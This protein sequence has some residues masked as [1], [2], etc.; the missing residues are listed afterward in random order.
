MNHL[1]LLS[2]SLDVLLFLSENFI[3]V[4]ESSEGEFSRLTGHG[5]KQCYSRTDLLL[6]LFGSSV[7]DGGKTC[8]NVARTLVTHSSVLYSTI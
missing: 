4:R 1:N 8:Q 2:I 6:F 7:T 3:V 5:V